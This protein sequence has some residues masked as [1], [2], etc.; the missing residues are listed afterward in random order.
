MK[1][2]GEGRMKKNALL[3]LACMGMIGSAQSST[4]TSDCTSHVFVPRSI[5]TDLVYIDAITLQKRW[6]GWHDLDQ[7]HRFL[8]YATPFYQRSKKDAAMGS[9]FLLNNGT[10]TVTVAQDTAC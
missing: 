9:A 1:T 8:F 3:L 2:Q 4:P 6:E 7:R 5:T 10:N